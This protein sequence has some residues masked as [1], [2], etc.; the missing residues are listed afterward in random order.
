MFDF[1]TYGFIQNAIL[2]GLM[3]GASAALLSPF[4]VLNQQAMIADGLSH[5]SFTGFVLGMLLVDEPLL[6][7]IP[8]VM[9]ASILIRYLSN[10]KQVNNDAAIGLVSAI[11]FAVG[12]IMI[13]LGSG[14]NISVETMLVGNMF[15][16]TPSEMWLSIIVLILITSFVLIFYRKLFLMTYDEDYARFQK[17]PVNKLSYVLSVLTALFIVVGVRTIGILLISALVIFPSQ[18]SS[19]WTKSFKSTLVLGTIA[20]L[21]VIPLGIIIAHPLSIPAGSTIVVLYAILLL[22]SLM[23]KSILRRFYS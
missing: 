4:L 13:K 15:T 18:M 12:L 21:I 14:F 23:L 8:F 9:V 5:A 3:L 19:Q 11:S 16:A 10:D 22:T 6:I 7:A 20:S 17:I 1:L 2:I